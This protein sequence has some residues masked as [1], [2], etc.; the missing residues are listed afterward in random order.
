MS[1][2]RLQKNLSN[3]KIV[4]LSFSLVLGLVWRPVPLASVASYIQSNPQSASS[5]MVLTQ[6][7]RPGCATAGNVS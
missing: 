4:S 3:T 5:I 2:Q 1:S 7:N 6:S